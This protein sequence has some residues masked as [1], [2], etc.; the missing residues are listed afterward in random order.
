MELFLD[1]EDKGVS[2]NWT[3]VGEIQAAVN[4]SNATR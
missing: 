4:E 2:Q 1:V 3:N